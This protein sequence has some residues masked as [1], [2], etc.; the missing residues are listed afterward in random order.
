M[1]RTHK[2]ANASQVQCYQDG[3]KVFKKGKK[4]KKKPEPKPDMLGSGLAAGAGE[5]IRDTRKKQM[6]D[7]GLKDGGKVKMKR[8]KKGRAYPKK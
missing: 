6:E 3:G 7:L 2:Y 5:A 4:G 8:S 1:R